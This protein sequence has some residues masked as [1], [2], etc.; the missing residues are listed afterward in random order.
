MSAAM[1]SGFFNAAGRKPR[2]PARP[3][4]M[5]R[6]GVPGPPA[7]GAAMTGTARPR[8]DS[9]ARMGPSCSRPGDTGAMII[10]DAVALVT[11]AS[12]GIGA[13]VAGAL[14]GRGAQVLVHGRDAT[15]TAAVAQRVGGTPLVADLGEP[16]AADRLAA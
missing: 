11:G 13:A 1:P 14:A 7:M 4:A 16:T 12:A 8:S 10:K 9:G 6:A 2:P 15:A 5:A 3:A